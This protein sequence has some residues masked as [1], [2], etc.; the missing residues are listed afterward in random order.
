MRS[1]NLATCYDPERGSSGNGIGRTSLC[2]NFCSF[3][4]TA[5]RDAPAYSITPV[6]L[7]KRLGG[8]RIAGSLEEREGFNRECNKFAYPQ[9]SG[10][11]EDNR[12]NLNEAHPGMSDSLVCTSICAHQ[13]SKSTRLFRVERWFLDTYTRHISQILHVRYARCAGV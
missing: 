6:R 13:P 2:P 4:V 1:E 10:T 5:K 11:K 7:R 12:V 8:R 3:I 9:L